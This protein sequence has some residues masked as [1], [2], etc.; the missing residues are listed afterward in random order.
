MSEWQIRIPDLNRDESLVDLVCAQSA[1]P[2]K[3]DRRVLRELVLQATLA[4]YGTAGELYD[5][6]E[7]AGPA[8]RRPIFDDAREAAGLKRSADI[9][10]AEHV[11]E[12][13]RQA[14][15]RAANRPIPTCA[16]CG[17]HPTGPAGFPEEVPPARRW[18]CREHV[19]QA[20]PGDMDPPLPP[21]DFNLRL[22][23][24]DEDAAAEREDER[25]REHHE[26]RKRERAA[27]AEVIRA[28]RE[29]W[30]RQNANDPFVNPWSGSGWSAP[31]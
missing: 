14:R 16:V 2:D 24:P 19:A 11:Q 29:R 28:A 8:G 9:D 27:E 7:D 5:R 12:L 18:H 3:E 13:Q 25:R 23:D 22:I 10:R 17:V 6:L 20:K 15:Q 4:G 26:Q 21:V 31:A 30:E 1:L